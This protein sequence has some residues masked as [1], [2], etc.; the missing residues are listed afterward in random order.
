[1]ANPLPS[2]IQHLRYF[3]GEYLRSYDFTDEQSYHIAMR[4][5]MNQKLHL[6]GI[7]CGLEI[8]EDAT[9]T[10]GAIFYSIS[11]GI[12]IDQAGREIV[13]PAPYSLSNLLDGPGL[14]VGSNEVWL[15]YQESETGLPAAGYLDCNVKNQNTRWQETFSVQLQPKNS[16][17]LFTGCGGVKLGNVTVSHPSTGWMI[18][19]PT[20]KGRWYVGIRAQEIKAPDQIDQSP[21]PYDITALTTPVTDHPLPGYLDVHPGVYNHGNV[22]VDKNLL[23]GP[24]FVLNPSDAS[25]PSYNTNLPTLTPPIAG[26]VKVS[27]DLF[28]QGSIYLFNGSVS[29]PNQWQQLAQPPIP[30]IQ[31]SGASFVSVPIGPDLTGS[32]TGSFPVPGVITAPFVTTNGQIM[33]AITGIEWRDPKDFS[34]WWGTNGTDVTVNVTPIFGPASAGSTQWNLTI[35]WTAGPAYDN[36]GQFVYPMKFVNVS[37]IVVFLPPS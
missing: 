15:C 5:L 6:C 25:G 33:L 8:V 13:V 17:S 16:P 19:A 14:T 21:D 35:Q 34:S 31:T 4:R 7:V 27:N 12:A 1:V 20:T 30:N 22:I 29:P 9:S 11:P 10:A 2:S 3:D 26:N 36:S 24:D 28:V 37:Y 18:S 32:G 23:V